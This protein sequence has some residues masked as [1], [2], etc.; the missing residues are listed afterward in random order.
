MFIRFSFV[1]L[2][3]S[4]QLAFA[5]SISVNGDRL[6]KR[7]Q[8]FFRDAVMPTTEQLQVSKNWTCAFF[9]ARTDDFNARNL[10]ETFR[11]EAI[12]EELFRSTA[13]SFKDIQFFL[14]E[15]SKSLVA[16]CNTA[17]CNVD[18]FVRVNT[19]PAAKGIKV[20][21]LIVEEAFSSANKEVD[22][23]L[24]PDFAV[25][26]PTQRLRGY[27][28]CSLM[29][30]PTQPVPA[31]ALS[32]D[33]LSEQQRSEV[34]Q[35]DS[36][37]VIAPATPSAASTADSIPQS[38]FVFS[39][40]P[41]VIPAAAVPIAALPAPAAALADSLRSSAGNLGAPLRKRSKFNADGSRVENSESG[42]ESNA[43]LIQKRRALTLTS[44]AT[45]LAP[46]PVGNTSSP[47]FVR[48]EQ[49]T[50]I[51]R[52]LPEKASEAHADVRM[53]EPIETAENAS[54]EQKEARIEFYEEEFKKLEDGEKTLRA[55][56]K[57][58]FCERAK[59]EITALKFIPSEGKSLY[60][61][62]YQKKSHLF[63]SI[64]VALAEAHYKISQMSQTSEKLKLQHL[65][66]ALAHIE[67][68]NPK[69]KIRVAT[70]ERR[71]KVRK[72]IKAA[73]AS[74]LKSKNQS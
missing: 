53:A 37:S 10:A 72:K 24:F 16:T 61:R 40:T 35:Q 2:A 47:S 50:F 14:D 4:F 33:A 46:A 58:E 42:I 48:V 63:V 65:H 29:Q 41:A 59:A 19:N 54:I 68:I 70:R 67:E 45:S 7:S 20:G 39:E 60:D 27:Y 57:I 17:A 25:S 71:D 43:E 31:P 69:S 3:L 30:R 15:E 64:S 36:F 28:Q 51:E 73:I 52:R 9:I 38:A 74:S 21:D 32:D 6:T 34:G 18:L 12:T 26:A 44:T 55:A 62:M 49:E 66:E 5:G 56:K 13:G 22:P 8:G 11:F 1:V 23:N